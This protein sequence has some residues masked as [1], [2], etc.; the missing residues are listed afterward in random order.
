[1][2][3]SML[4]T[5]CLIVN[6][7]NSEQV[8]S[9]G[10]LKKLNIELVIDGSGSLVN[11]DTPTDPSGL[12]YDAINLF[13]ALLANKGNEVGAIVFDDNS[14]KYIF[15][16]DVASVEGKQAKMNLADKIKKAGTGVDTDIGSALKTAVEALKKHQADNDNASA[17]ILMSD[18][19]AHK[20]LV[21]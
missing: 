8:Q 2:I 4:T 21:K 6:A 20:V 1:M 15:N 14:E 7:D 17:V 18:G 13:L 16:A 19:T 9:T 3:L 11:G 5:E 12:R 10:E